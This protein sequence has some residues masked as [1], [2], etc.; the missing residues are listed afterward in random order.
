MSL[1]Y[2]FA[3]YFVMWWIVWIAVLP[4][5]VRTA[6]ETGEETVP[7]QAHS[8][9]QNPM[10]RR[11]VLWT[12]AVTTVLF[13]LFWANTHYRWLTIDDLPLPSAGP[14]PVTSPTS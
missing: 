12:T 7:G 1:I 11:K 6:H 3:V 4:W 9:P 14:V 5:G 2:G 8:A 13:L 10:L